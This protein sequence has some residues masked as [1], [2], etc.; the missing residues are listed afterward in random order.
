MAPEERWWLGIDV[1]GTFT[2]LVAVSR[3]TGEIRDLKVLT[4]RPRQEEGVLAAVRGIGID[5]DRIDEIVHGHTTGI[6]AALSRQGS[7]TALLA[8]AGHRDL[9]DLGRMDREFGPN[10]YDPTWL[11]P[12]QERP[13]I[14]RRDRY[15]IRER[16][17]SDGSVLLELDEQQV[18][19]IARELREQDVESVAIC[20][21]LAEKA[22]KLLG[23]AV[24]HWRIWDAERRRP[25]PTRRARSI[26]PRPSPISPRLAHA[27]CLPKAPSTSPRS[28]PGA[29]LRAPRRRRPGR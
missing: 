20:F 22:G 16:I 28:S 11:R 2:D 10:L 9:L 12:H 24:E 23:S 1:G 19:Q 5:V 7:A 21:Y 26:S 29:R 4:T 3:D 13:L 14:R 27:R 17:G 6:N 15:G 8:T 25:L 18:R